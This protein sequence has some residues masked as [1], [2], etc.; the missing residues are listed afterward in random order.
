VKHLNKI[1]QF[2]IRHK[3]I[4]APLGVIFVLFIFLY[5]F[6][7][8]SAL[9][10]YAETKI[11]S[12]KIRP[13]KNAL[14]RQDLP[15]L[16]FELEYFRKDLEKIN[17]S[18]H[19]IGLFSAVP[20]V[21]G[22]AL[23]L[24]NLSSAAILSYDA[25][26]DLLERLIPN[27]P[28]INF[29]G[30][31]GDYTRSSE[32][33]KID[34]LVSAVPN[35]SQ[36][37]PK[38][39][40]RLETVEEQINK[41]D[42]NRYPE[43][44]RGRNIR[45]LVLQL[46]QGLNKLSLYFDDLSKTLAAAPQIIGV[47]QP[48]NYL[49]I[50]QNDKELRPGGGLLAG[51]AAFVLD[52]GNVKMTKSGDMSFL[53]E[54]VS[55]TRPLSPNFI[56]RALGNPHLYIKDA[57]F[58][59]DFKSTAQAIDE[60]WQTIPGNNPLD[61]VVVFDTQFVKSLLSSLG[62]VSISSNQ[63]VGVNN[64]DRA[65]QNFFRYTGS[66]AAEGRQYKDLTSA[67]LNELLKKAFFG[68]A[69]NYP[70]LGKTILELGKGRHFQIYFKNNDLQNLVEKL[71]LAGQVKDFDGD[72]LNINLGSYSFQRLD[73]LLNGE[74]IKSGQLNSGGALTTNLKVKLYLKPEGFLPGGQNVSYFTRIYV[75]KGS[76]LNDASGFFGPLSSSAELGKTVYSGWV[77]LKQNQETTTTIRYTSPRLPGESRDLL[78][79]KQPGTQNFKYK[80]S[81]GNESKEF[82][83][84][85]D[86]ELTL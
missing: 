32:S 45:S 27:L 70:A 6:L 71:D 19:K 74:I 5:Y 39:K 48:R 36:E 83:L 24:K 61:G 16:K 52:N 73:N 4:T 10:L 23:D 62:E 40:E 78:I 3:K 34:Q 31:A 54:Q 50:I 26:S 11:I 38:F 1:K 15:T 7:I 69:K 47:S 79:Q 55:R 72:Y 84:S 30:Y 67:L 51:Y 81:L 82:E 18:T 85:Q 35:I 63:S 68:S 25:F 86:I 29:G 43:N 22:Y 17:S 57:N 9:F 46:K 80:V 41:I 13:I 64:M 58:S 60:I 65:L 44:F 37:L 28:Q 42:E 56:S 33:S 49:V 20:V 77:N 59:P 75:P 21:G 53:D 14:E 2:L 66:R 12:L 8:E 76:I